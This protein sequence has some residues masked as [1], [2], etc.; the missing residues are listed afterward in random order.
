[1]LKQLDVISKT[2]RNWPIKDSRDQLKL[3]ESS[4]KGAGKLIP[5]STSHNELVVHARQKSTNIL[6]DPHA[7]LQLFGNREELEAAQAAESVKAPK[8]GN[9][10]QQ[11]DFA[12]ILGDNPQDQTTDA[13]FHR[14]VSPT[15][16]G[17]GK[18]HQGMRLF[19]GSETDALPDQPLVNPERLIRPHPGKYNH[20]EFADG[21]DPQDAPKP[22]VDLDKREKSKHDSQWSFDDFTTPHR[23]GPT[24]GM[25][26]QDLR[27]WDPE[28]LN[29]PAEKELPLG[30]ARRD[31]EA[32]FELQD[33]GERPADEEL[34][35]RP[36]R[37]VGHNEG[38][39]LY[40]NQI[41]DKGDPA[42]G[43]ERALGNITNLKDRGK[44]FDAHFTMT[45]NSPS[46]SKVVQNVTETRQKVVK[47][48]DHNWEV[49]E[50]S[51]LKEN[52]PKPSTSNA[53]LGIMHIAGDG[54]GGKKGSNRNWLYGDDDEANKPAPRNAQPT[55]GKQSF[56]DF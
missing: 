18:N 16:I 37:G 54:M 42:A 22:G 10:P 47:M 55:G 28:T 26:S 21:S 29:E 7:T 1:M 39:G 13:P 53:A 45:D 25:R 27:H 11:R 23:A 33:D 56:W 41:F 51:P 15:K 50:Q 24:R 31:A 9:R 40:K 32:H 43:P 12:E 5:T 20:F 35:N 2:G 34:P 17:Q 38:L 6:R 44:D 36:P 3:I 52:Q 14:P 48:M 8:A 30:R 49:Y 46:G 19:E 4:L